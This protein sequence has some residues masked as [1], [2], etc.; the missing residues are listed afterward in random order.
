MRA[1]QQKED[2]IN[3]DNRAVG[4]RKEDVVNN[5][6]GAVGNRKEDVVNNDSSQTPSTGLRHTSFNT[7]ISGY[8]VGVHKLSS[9]QRLFDDAQTA[10]SL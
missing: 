1:V 5:D 10:V 6:N 7:A 8:A 9:N 2:V 4:N 3:N